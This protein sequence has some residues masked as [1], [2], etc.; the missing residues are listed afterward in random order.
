MEIRPFAR[1]VGAPQNLK[2]LAKVAI[3]GALV[4][5]YN[6]ANA[7]IAGHPNTV[8]VKTLTDCLADSE[9]NKTSSNLCVGRITS[10][11]INPTS[12]PP[13]QKACSDR[14][15]VVWIETLN[16]DL[17]DLMRRTPEGALKQAL[18]EVQRNFYAEKVSKCAFE[19]NLHGN[20]PAALFAASACDVQ[21]TARQ[22]F[23]LRAQMGTLP[24]E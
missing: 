8:D 4:L 21:S 9:K 11:C 7:A 17:A 2:L 3:A 19:R 5:T 16:R 13:E 14:E 12:T 15:L 6:G 24:N 23:W 1:R 10:Q 20:S 18:A 22:D